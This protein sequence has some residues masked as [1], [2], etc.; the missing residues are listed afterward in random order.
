[1]SEYGC[2]DRGTTPSLGQVPVND[3]ESSVSDEFCA[4]VCQTYQPAARALR[5]VLTCVIPRNP[6]RLCVDLFSMHTGD[7]IYICLWLAADTGGVL[8]DRRQCT[9]SVVDRQ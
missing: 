8:H 4:W 5:V 3:G 2:F 6:M 9:G 1:V 7:G